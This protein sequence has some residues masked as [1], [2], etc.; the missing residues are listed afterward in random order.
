MSNILHNS[1]TPKDSPLNIRKTC[2]R[3][4]SAKALFSSV[5]SPNRHRGLNEL[6]ASANACIDLLSKK[7]IKMIAI[8]ERNAK[9]ISKNIDIDSDL[10]VAGY[11]LGAQ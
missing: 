5:R 11:N 4:L 8:S 7:D 9:S 2:N 6:L 1:R 3:R 10:Y